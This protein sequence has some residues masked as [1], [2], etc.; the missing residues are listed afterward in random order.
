MVSGAADLVLLCGR[1]GVAL[2]ALQVAFFLH[3][4]VRVNLEHDGFLAGELWCVRP[5]DDRQ[6]FP[7]PFAPHGPSTFPRLALVASSEVG[8]DS[9][10]WR[11]PLGRQPS[12]PVVGSPSHRIERGVH[13]SG[14]RVCRGSLVVVGQPGVSCILLVR[15]RSEDPSFRVVPVLFARRGPSMELLGWLDR[16][17]RD[18]RSVGVALVHI[19]PSPGELRG[20]RRHRTDDDACS[21]LTL[22]AHASLAAPGQGGASIVPLGRGHHEGL[23]EHVLGLDVN[24]GGVVR[25]CIAHY[26]SDRQG[27]DPG[28]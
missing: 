18:P 4:V 6:R 22:D 5:V 10:A 21:H 7:S 19:A 3:R 25:I 17:H 27:N 15:D 26:E 1:D 13:G 28:S 16:L 2:A 12:L 8:S 24:D 23:A 14:D 11:L 20:W 9:V